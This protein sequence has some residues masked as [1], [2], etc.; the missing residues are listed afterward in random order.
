MQVT[1]E[2]IESANKIDLVDYLTNKGYQLEK[3]GSSYKIKIRQKFS[4]DMSSLSV[5]ENR[6]GWKRWSSGE[7]G[8][9][10]ISFL[11]KNMGMNF[12]DAV[13]ELTGGTLTYAAAFIPPK[14]AESTQIPEN[15]ELV[16][17]KKCKGKYSR[18]LA[19]LSKSRLIDGNIISKMIADKK[20]YQD[21]RNNVVFVGFNEKNEAAFACVRGTNTQIQ[22]RGDCEGSDKRYAFSIDGTN[23]HGKL[24]V[25][26]APIDLLSHAT[27]ANKVT[28]NPNAWAAHS[29]ISLA[30][31]SDFALEHY[32]KSH[33]EVREIHFVLDNDK[34]GREAAA[35][36]VPKYEKLG[37]K[38]VDHVLKTKDMNQELEAYINKPPPVKNKVM[39][40]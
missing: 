25:F 39:K 1:K 34:A 16:L 37:F 8:G 2:Q 10:A 30:G 35:K 5:F 20:I 3:K 15:K 31:T 18:A 28:N 32:L 27:M 26:E 13:L 33:P 19:Y 38:V 17:P 29:R 9:D 22:Y 21:E 24:Y 11:Q 6:R 7:H 36:Y 12:Q 4:G 40:R 14:K 23:S